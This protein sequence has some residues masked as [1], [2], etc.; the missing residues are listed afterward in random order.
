M[1]IGSLSK[2]WSSSCV[3]LV[4]STQWFPWH[5]TTSGSQSI[6]YIKMIYQVFAPRSHGS[7]WHELTWDP[8][9]GYPRSRQ[10]NGSPLAWRAPQAPAFPTDL[11]RAQS[12]RRP[13]PLRSISKQSVYSRFQLSVDFHPFNH[14][15]NQIVC[16]KSTIG[17]FL[18]LICVFGMG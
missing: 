18:S 13:K 7:P 12:S 9:W 10:V 4:L 5:H 14:V 6:L 1:S 17:W 8:T 3:V 2:V 15:R 11:I 16:P